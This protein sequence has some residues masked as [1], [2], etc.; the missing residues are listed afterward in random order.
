MKSFKILIVFLFAF[1]LFSSNVN[2]QEVKDYS[3]MTKED[4]LK[5]SY[6]DLLA[7]P[8]EDLLKL[9]EIVG[10]SADELLQMILN[11]N[12]ST[13]SKKMETV[14][15]SPLST[16]VITKEEIIQSGATTIEELFRT[17][18]G[19]IVREKSNGNYDVHIR[20][21]DNIPPG[22]FNHFSENTMTLVMID[23]RIVYNYVNGGIFW[24]TLP[25]ELIDIE[26]IDVIR[27]PSS[28]LYGASAVTGVINIITKKYYG[29]KI[30]VEG[31]A[32]YG[33]NNSMIVG[34]RVAKG[35]GEKFSI[36]LSGNADKRDR[37]ME[38]YWSYF[39]EKYVDNDSILSLFRNSY[40]GA[41]KLPNPNMSKSKYGTNL[42][43]NFKP[44]EKVEINTTLGYQKSDIQTVFFENLATPFSRRMSES[45]YVNFLGKAYNFQS[46]FSYLKGTQDLS[47]GM[48]E[49]VIKYDMNVINAAIEYDFNYKSL[50]IRPG[51][52]FQQSEYDD[53]KWSKEARE[54][55]NSSALG[56][57]EGKKSIN[58]FSG[59]LRAEYTLFEKLRLIS[60]LRYEKFSK[61]DD[62]YL[63]YQFVAA[64]NLTDDYIVRAV[65][66]RANRS[67]FVG[68][69]YSNYKNALVTE[70]FKVDI[71]PLNIHVDTIVNFYYQ[72]YIGNPD[73]KLLTTDMYEVGIRN[74]I[75]KQVQTDF[76]VFYSESKNIDLLITNEK[77]Y[78]T[79]TNKGVKFI[80]NVVIMP[81]GTVIPLGIPT[82]SFPAITHDKRK[83]TNMDVRSQQTG[84]SGN[85]NIVPI[86][87][88]SI[89]LFGTYQIT[90]LKDYAPDPDNKIDSLIDIEHKWTPSFYGGVV[91]IYS[92]IKKLSLYSNATYYSEQEFMRYQSP[93]NKEQNIDKIAAKVIVNAKLTYKI[94]HNINVFL[95]ARNA[96]SQT[97]REFGFAD[98]SLGLYLAGF[99][100]SF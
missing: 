13:A 20:G 94:N 8:F 53:T 83:Y 71:N 6:D 61:P 46:Q 3:K 73:M 55:I 66:S 92:P 57:F 82:G 68:T 58:S 24:E 60:A 75:T 100:V 42:F 54:K 21:N 81:N 76:E 40:G 1:S 95:N 90:R 27:G 28:A 34:F 14:F 78:D 72:Y 5:M 23:N 74:K 64:Y 87:N 15:E 48:T 77:T 31:K 18:P 19:M 7:L 59:S 65:V 25:I 63:S 35:F 91:V 86:K 67:A 10:V 69:A 84:M 96:F 47:Y 43:I 41:D 37:F 50:S 52:A 9:S 80:N 38:E 12:V 89:R 45:G 33:T 98:K 51:L 85:I 93:N 39:A 56:L 26:R 44:N 70:R 30:K 29:E 2:A 17:V 97:D 36:G 99:N 32:E 79:I 62:A 49:P 22:N 88:L 16:T 4:V 11:T